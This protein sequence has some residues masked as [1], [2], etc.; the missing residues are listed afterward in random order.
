MVSG[1]SSRIIR[2][3]NEDETLQ[4]L[5][6]KY[7]KDYILNKIFDEKI[8]SYQMLLSEYQRFVQGEKSSLFTWM[9]VVN[10]DFGIVIDEH[11]YLCHFDADISIQQKKVFPW[12]YVDG[13]KFLGDSWW[14]NDEEII[15][16]VKTLSIINFLKKYKGY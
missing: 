11:I 3:S 4:D 1:I 8:M 10:S 5:N 14:F 15:E 16:D 6:V 9:Y 2:M 12:E 13:K 7:G